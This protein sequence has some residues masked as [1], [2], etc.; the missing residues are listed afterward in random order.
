MTRKRIGP[1][2]RRYSL[3]RLDQ[4]EKWDGEDRYKLRLVIGAVAVACILFR[5]DRERHLADP[6][7]ILLHCSLL[8][9]SSLLPSS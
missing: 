4:P 2:P 3:D 1:T 9:G 7:Q 6:T 8:T 5:S